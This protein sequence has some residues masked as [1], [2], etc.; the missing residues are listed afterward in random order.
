MLHSDVTDNSIKCRLTIIIIII[1]IRDLYR[2]ISDFKKG[3]QSRT[4]MVKDETGDL[5]TGSY[6]NLA[7]YRD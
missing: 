3:C 7:W 4:H 2:G 1:I 6:S 5:V